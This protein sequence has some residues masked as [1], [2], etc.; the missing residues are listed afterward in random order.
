[1]TWAPT[2]TQKA[3]YA[4]L[5]GDSTLRT[6]CGKA[7]GVA[8]VFDHVPENQ[9]FPYISIFEM[10]FDDRGNHTKEGFESEFQVSVFYQDPKRGNKAVQDIQ[11]RIDALLHKVNICVAGWN[12]ISMRRTTIEILL[13]DDN[14]TRHGVQRF[15][16]RLGE[17]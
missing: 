17:Q 12:V 5:N 13:E 4:L 14:V 8:F 10:P 1:M 7:S 16:L 2:E 9:V 11:A 6:L 3:I 15:R